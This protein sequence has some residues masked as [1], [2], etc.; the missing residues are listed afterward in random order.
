M[1][2]FESIE[3]FFASSKS[4]QIPDPL[5]SALPAKRQV[6]KQPI[7]PKALPKQSETFVA[8]KPME[9][10]FKQEEPK[11]ETFYTEW[12]EKYKKLHAGN[13]LAKEPFKRHAL[14]VVDKKDDSPFAMKICEAISTR[15]MKATYC[16]LKGSLDDLIKKVAPSHLI[17]TFTP[18]KSPSL[19][20]IYI[21][22]LKEIEKEPFKKKA[23]WEMLKT[24]LKEN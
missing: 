5:K 21:D 13:L 10:A 16:P 9:P 19:P 23:L 3:F 11:K 2:D 7:L 12:E 15:L 4:H 24:S 8:K 20:T 18:E 14:F 6:E 1:S 17:L 22:D